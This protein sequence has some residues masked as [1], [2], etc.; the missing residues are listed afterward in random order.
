M[1]K[2]LKNILSLNISSEQFGFLEG[3][4]I[5]EAIGVAQEGLYTMKTQKLKGAVIKIYLSKSYDRVSWLYIRMLLTHL[6]FCYEFTRWIMAC[7]TTVSFVVLI[8]GSVSPFFLAGRGLRQ[9]CLLSPL[10]FLLVAEGLSRFILLAKADGSFR[11]IPISPVLYITH[12]F[13]VDEILLFCDGSRQDIDKLYEGLNLLQTVAGML[14]NVEK[15]TISC[16]NLS[17]QET[18]RILF[19]LPYRILELDEGLKY[20][21][22]FLKPNYYLKAD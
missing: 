5:H 3:R 9:G 13:F 22:F 2:R 8:N 17:E 14:V 1:A 18:Q 19:R 11:G 21:G 15:S 12:L 20:L 6:G 10:L 7:I 4:Q 16:S